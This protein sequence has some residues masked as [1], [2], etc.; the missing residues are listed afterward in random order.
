M[1]WN[2]NKPDV[3]T[4]GPRG[5]E[6]IHFTAFGNTGRVLFQM[7]SPLPG[8]GRRVRRSFTVRL[9]SSTI[10]Y[11]LVLAPRREQSPGAIRAPFIADWRVVRVG[12][13]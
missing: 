10:A 2:T 11:V 1:R 5:E 13:G 12:S 4:T 3:S 8:L 9:R 6:G 7:L